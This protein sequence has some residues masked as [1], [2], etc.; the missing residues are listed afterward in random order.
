MSLK[1]KVDAYPGQSYATAAVFS[2]AQGWTVLLDNPARSWHDEVKG[3]AAKHALEGALPVLEGMVL[4][5][6]ART[7]AVLEFAKI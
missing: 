3:P 7:R 4:G 1:V 5:L 6:L 2:A